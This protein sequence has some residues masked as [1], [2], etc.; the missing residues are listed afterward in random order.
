VI[1]NSSI[2]RTGLALAPRLQEKAAELLTEFANTRAE[3]C[4]RFD[5]RWFKQ[6]GQAW[7]AGTGREVGAQSF[8][9]VQQQVQEIWEGKH[10]DSESQIIAHGL[11]LLVPRQE[12]GYADTSQLLFH[13]SWESGCIWAR[14]RDLGD[15]VWLSLLQYSRQLAVCGNRE[16]GCPAPYFIRKKPNQKFCSDAC[17]LP[18]QREFKRRWFREHGE[19]WRRKWQK[20]RERNTKESRRRRA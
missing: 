8:L 19:E 20:K 2:N 7:Y 6:T 16:N 13:V 1:I 4:E 5:S 17:A 14:P 18:A 10:K 12:E 3:D 11:S 9:Q 15:Y